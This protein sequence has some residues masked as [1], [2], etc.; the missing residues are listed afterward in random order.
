M[1]R[2]L[3]SMVHVVGALVIGA[4]CQGNADRFVE[5]EVNVAPRSGGA[6]A[7]PWGRQPDGPT[8]ASDDDDDAEDDDAGALGALGLGGRG[9]PA[10][11]AALALGL[12][13]P[14]PYEAPDAG[15]AATPGAPAM[16]VLELSGQI[17]EQA[18]YSASGKQGLPLR[19]LTS[20]LRQ[21]AADPSTTGLLVRVSGLE[22]S[23]PDAVELRAAMGAWKAAGKPLHCHAETVSG[24]AYVVMAACDTLGLAPLGEVVLAGPSAMPVHLKPAMDKLGLTADF[25]HVGAFKGAAEPLTRDAPSPEMLETMNAILDRRYQSMVDMVATSRRLTPAAVEAI[26]DEA[27]LPAPRALATKVVDVVEPWEA[28]RERL[29]GQAWREVPLEAALPPQAAMAKLMAFAGMGGA[30]R[31]SGPHV[32]LV[33]AVGDV[34]DGDGDGVMGARTQIAS[35]TLIAA[36]RALAADD[37]VKAVVVRI[38][39]GGGSAL[40]SE[41]IWHEMAALKAKKPVIVS[42]SDVAASGGY[43]IAAPADMIFALDDTLTGSIGVVGGKL[44]PGGALD[45]L[46]VKTYPMGRGKR[47]T[48]FSNL[49]PWSSD[50]R[51]AVQGMMQATY[52]T[53]V[54]RVAAGRRKSATE[55]QPIAQGRVWVGTEARRLGLVDAIGGLD[56]ALAEATRRAG[57]SPEAELEVYPPAPTLRDVAVRIG[58]V[59]VGALGVDA[60]IGGLAAQALA[61]VSPALAERTAA[62]WTTLQS[63]VVAPVQTVVL[64]PPIR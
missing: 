36:L 22:V 57:L 38:D 54:G 26:I 64:L 33:Y 2:N 52:E 18:E 10:T 24:T 53:F 5:R 25:L 44:A 47:A 15:D 45:K 35:H 28:F 59:G 30:A 48:M 32:A 60:D 14:G 46:G 6:T 17:V 41:L 29:A 13:T 55:I 7:N 58:V 42:M 61:D 37:D 39:S 4:G 20:R 3:A 62:L 8:I 11:L 16:A 9:L 31:P 56:D 19:D 51:A 63:F 21:L 12:K 50:E 23:Q 34:V 43:Y 40:A 27:M 1:A 49:G